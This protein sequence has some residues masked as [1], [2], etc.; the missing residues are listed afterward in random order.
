MSRRRQQNNRQASSRRSTR[1]AGKR[2]QLWWY[3]IG[4]A[5]V[6]AVLGWIIAGAGE[7]EGLVQAVSS[8]VEIPDPDTSLMSSRGSKVIG[9]ARQAVVD[10]P[11]SADAWGLFG[12]LCDIHEFNDCAVTCYRNGRRL[13]PGDLRFPY[14]LAIVRERQ[15]AHWSEVVDLFQ[16]AL[17]LKP[18]FPPVHF[19]IGHAL[20][21]Q[22]K[23][24]AACDAY[25]RAI[26]L[27]GDLAI[28]HRS[29]GQ[30]LITRNEPAAAVRHLELAAQLAPE[31][32]PVFAALARGYRLLGAHQRADEAAEKSSRLGSVLALPDPI[33]FQVESLRTRQR[34]GS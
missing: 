25:R 23:L 9:E 15:G 32:G 26:E 21:R 34:G 2:P 14:H 13:S 8:T 18:E 10:R 28:A 19:R 17:L 29:L 27:D 24:E 22:G 12:A 6:L 31:D 33:R 3:V 7:D 4:T 30:V 16:Q 1:K 11:A 20:S 5:V